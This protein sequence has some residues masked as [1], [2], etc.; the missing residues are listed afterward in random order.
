MSIIAKT[1]SEKCYEKKLCEF[2]PRTE[3]GEKILDFIGTMY[4]ACDHGLCDVARTYRK[5]YVENMACSSS[6]IHRQEPTK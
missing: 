4:E 2:C 5:D 6:S 1:W 3:H